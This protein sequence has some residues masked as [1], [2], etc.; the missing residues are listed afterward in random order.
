MKKIAG[1]SMMVAALALSA[2]GSKDDGNAVTPGKALPSVAAPAGT[3]WADTV[4]ATP[5]GGM[6]MGNPNA[7][8][9]V[10]E[11]AS[12][13]CSHCAEF[14]KESSEEIKRDFV[15][16]GKVSYELRNYIRDPIDLS[17]AM[18]ARC[19]GP[20]PFFP[21]TDQ[22]FANQAAIFDAVKANG[23]DAAYQAAM[24]QPPA[25]RFVALAKLAGL[26]DFAKQRGVSEDQ[27]R[28]CLADEKTAQTLSDNVAKANDQY[29]IQGTP[30]IL[31]NGKVEE[32]LGTWPALRSRLKELGA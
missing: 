1:L 6:L 17:A 28:R 31:I 7:A 10:V 8:V 20:E 18:I 27:A 11:F 15:N 30:T 24:T 21:L 19:A 16:S 26:I 5:D 23:G 14:S 29:N 3:S 9:K 32:N 12:Y 4:V 25:Q 22:L 2:C 13:T